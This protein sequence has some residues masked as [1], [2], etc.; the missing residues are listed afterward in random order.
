[1]TTTPPPAA[2]VTIERITAFL[3]GPATS[4]TRTSWACAE[5]NAWNGP[6]PAGKPGGGDLALRPSAGRSAA[7][8]GAGAPAGATGPADPAAQGPWGLRSCL[9]AGPGRTARLR[10]RTGR[11]GVGWQGALR[12][13]SAGVGRPCLP[14]AR[15][16]APHAPS[17][18]PAPC[19]RRPVAPG[20][21][22]AAQTAVAAFGPALLVGAGS[23]WPGAGRGLGPGWE[24][25]G[26]PCVARLAGAG[27]CG[28][29]GSG[30]VLQMRVTRDSS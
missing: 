23:V 5:G 13:L 9:K 18:A 29:S 28:L 1:M 10:P 11:A 21:A 19:R 14:P 8:G 7:A 3:P 27:C 15:A 20:E 16:L 2:R 25:A 4:C 30:L 22:L 24:G 12:D 26:T 6:V 17:G